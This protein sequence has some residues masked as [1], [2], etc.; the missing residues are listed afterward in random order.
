[1]PSGRLPVYRISKTRLWLLAGLI[2]YVALFQWTYGNWL[3]P[4][5][6]YYGFHL[7]SP[8]IGYLALGWILSVAPGIWLPIGLTRPSQLL[9]WTLYLVVYIPSMFAPLY[10]SLQ[11]PSEVAALM[12][13]LFA[14]LVLTSISYAWPLLRI[15]YVVVPRIIFGYAVAVAVIALLAWT[16]AVFWGHMKLVSFTQIYTELR[17]A[18]DAVTEGSDVKYGMML[19]AGVF[20][21]LLMSWGLVRKRPG[22]FFAGAAGQVML[23]STFGSKAILLSV[24][25]VPAFFL[26]LWR[27]PERFG[28]KFA[29]AVAGILLALDLCDIAFDPGPNDLLFM[30]TSLVVMRMLGMPGLLTGQYH[31]FFASHPLTH[32]SQVRAIGSYADYPYEKPI[33][34]VI[35]NYYTGNPD[36]NSNA[37]FWATDG[38]AGFGAPGILLISILCGLIFW[39]LDSVSARHDKVLVALTLSYAASNLANISLFTSLYSGGLGMLILLLYLMPRTSELA[40]IPLF[41]RA[42][43]ASGERLRSG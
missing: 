19:L 2:A 14:G 24:V 26:L 1:M 9:I 4:R 17:F 40:R 5:F 10:M 13:S 20:D 23:Y 31:D 27:Q 42:D 15:K 12:V 38:I 33:G 32:F 28:I 21:P 43:R 22:L 6:D 18:A 34:L 7:I 11:P 36:L 8:G 35:G 3:H 25:I 29:W 39:L 16:L 41:V 30:V 37:H